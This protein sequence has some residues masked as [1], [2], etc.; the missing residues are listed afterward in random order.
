VART[1]AARIASAARYH[2]VSLQRDSGELRSLSC[3]VVDMLDYG[4]FLKYG[5]GPRL[6]TEVHEPL[7]SFLQIAGLVSDQRLVHSITC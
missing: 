7:P 4:L 3:M 2:T 5:E 6:N 1:T